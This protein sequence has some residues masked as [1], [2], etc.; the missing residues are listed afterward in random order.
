MSPYIYALLSNLSWGFSAQFY[1]LYSRKIS[2]VW[3]NIFKCILGCI[4]F[5]FTVIFTGGFSALPFGAIGLFFLSGFIGL[6]VADILFFKSF[7]VIGSS[8]TIIIISFETLFVGVMSYYFFGQQISSVK[9]LSIFFL[10]A[11][12]FIFALENYKKTSKWDWR[13][14]L[15]AIAGTIL[16]SIGVIITRAAFNMSNA[17]A[18][19]ANAIRFIGAVAALAIIAP[20]MKA[21]FFERLKRIP[22]KALLGISAGAFIGTYLCMLFY[23]TALKTGNLAIISAMLCT[24]VIFAAAF[25][26]FLE[27]KWPSKYLLA[28]IGLFLCAMLILFGA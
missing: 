3:V 9:F 13:I 15:I 5:G 10:L 2:P 23:L 21:R 1:T 11:C 24:G 26:C 7:S 25:E 19:E 16:D 17:A 4:L 27:R 6:G 8:R 22:P 18:P 12:V 14:I 28:A 20:V